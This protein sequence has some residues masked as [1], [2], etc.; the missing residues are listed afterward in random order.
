MRIIIKKF[1][2]MLLTVSLFLYFYPGID[3]NMNIKSIFYGS[4]LLSLYYYLAKPFFNTLLFPINLLTFGLTKNIIDVVILI[5]W[6]YL[7]PQV[8]FI[9]WSI[10]QTDLIFFNIKSL[11]IP[12]ILSVVLGSIILSMFIKFTDWIFK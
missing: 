1:F 11:Y 10:N 2:L 8:Q 9:S 4:I 5:I 12:T 6:S 3:K 7:V